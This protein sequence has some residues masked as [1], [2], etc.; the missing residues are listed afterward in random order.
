MANHKDTARPPTGEI[1]LCLECA[2]KAKK[3]ADNDGEF[4][5]IVDQSVP[6][7]STWE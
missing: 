3:E 6:G 4:D 7:A 2:P 5:C 1:F